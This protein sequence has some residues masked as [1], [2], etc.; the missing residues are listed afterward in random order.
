MTETLRTFTVTLTKEQLEQL[1]A[2]WKKHPHI[3]NRSDFVRE[4][5]NAYAGKQIFQIKKPRYL[6]ELEEAEI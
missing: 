3:F 5:I 6:R 1:N 2:A 4:A